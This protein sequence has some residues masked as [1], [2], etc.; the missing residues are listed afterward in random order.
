MPTALFNPAPERTL[1]LIDELLDPDLSLREVASRHN[2]SL[3]ALSLWIASDETSQTLDALRSGFCDRIRTIAAANIAPTITT[4]NRLLKSY[5]ATD[6]STLTLAERERTHAVALRAASLFF[7]ITTL[8]PTRI[9]PP[10]IPAAA[11]HPASHTHA[12][13]YASPLYATPTPA[14]SA[15]LAQALIAA[16]QES[17]IAESPQPHPAAIPP[18]VPCAP[19]SPAALDSI[20]PELITAFAALLQNITD[21]DPLP[22]LKSEATESLLPVAANHEHWP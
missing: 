20:P 19:A 22:S 1:L 6:L 4:L 13:R 18:E 12:P 5:N 21:G 8:R 16:P 9:P 10:R 17:P 3:A 2:T 14:A 11:S 7:R 15:P